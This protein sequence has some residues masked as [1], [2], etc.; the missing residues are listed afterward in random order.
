MRFEEKLYLLR[1]E[2][3]I[4]QNELAEILDVSRQAISRWE[5]G[6][7]KPDTNHLIA[8]SQYFNVSM[9]YL[10]NDDINEKNEEICIQK[11]DTP[12]IEESI[13][14]KK[15]S[16][17]GIFLIIFLTL[18]I[19]ILIWGNVSHSLMGASISLFSAV[20]LFAIAISY[21]RIRNLVHEAKNKKERSREEKLAEDKK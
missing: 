18:L 20:I 7:T 17:R 15:R 14:I 19:S 4:S 13:S 16:I 2:K 6:R 1:E 12:K 11:K 8:I 5:V 3:K 9:D 21:I 10:V